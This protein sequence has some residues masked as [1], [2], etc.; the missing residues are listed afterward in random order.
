MVWQNPHKPSEQSKI[1]V[2]SL[3][4]NVET[5]QQSA[6]E[7]HWGN[8]I[9]CCDGMV[10]RSEGIDLPARLRSQ[11][12]NDLWCIKIW[13]SR[14]QYKRESPQCAQYALPFWIKQATIVV[15]GV[16]GKFFS[17]RKRWISLC[18]ARKPFSKNRSG[19]SIIGWACFGRGFL[20]FASQSLR[21]SHPWC[22]R[23]CRRP[24]TAKSHHV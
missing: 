4:R 3:Q 20:S 10:F 21:P 8:W 1:Q 19:L 16:S 14:I 5:I 18:A 2:T 24:A 17:W 22:V 13:P 23:P 11:V 15:R 7:E 12:A 9:I 6:H